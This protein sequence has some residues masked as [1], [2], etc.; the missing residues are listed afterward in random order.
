MDLSNVR[1][2][3]A[4]KALRA[5]TP[6]NLLAMQKL[7]TEAAV[8]ARAMLSRNGSIESVPPTTFSLV[9]A[10]NCWYQGDVPKAARSDPN[11]PD[12]RTRGLNNVV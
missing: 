6:E 12:Y 5:I 9:E 3:A 7:I 8:K 10:M 11:M 2:R 1:A 4:G